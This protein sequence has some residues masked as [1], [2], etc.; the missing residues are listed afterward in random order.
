MSKVFGT[1]WNILLLGVS[2]AY[3]GSLATVTA[4]LGKSALE[5]HQRGLISL[6]QLSKALQNGAPKP[7]QAHK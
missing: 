1:I 7:R 4:C 5:L 2:L 3:F 6:T